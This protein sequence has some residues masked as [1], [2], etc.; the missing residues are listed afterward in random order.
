MGRVY[1]HVMSV[2][3]CIPDPQGSECEDLSACHKHA[4]KIIRECLPFIQGDPRRWWMDIE[5]SKGEKKL[6]VLYP[7]RVPFGSRCF[8]LQD[9]RYW[10]EF[11]KR[12]CAAGHS[13]LR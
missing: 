1:F 5:N 10:S 7:R 2:D 12:A 13:E 6:T 8:L 3:E 4:L 11:L 9:E